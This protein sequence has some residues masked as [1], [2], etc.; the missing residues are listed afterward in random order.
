MWYRLAVVVLPLFTMAALAQVH[1]IP[2]SVTSGDHGIPASVTS[3]GPNGFGTRAAPRSCD[4]C[5]SL[6]S[7][8]Y[9]IFVP[10]PVYQAVFEA[11]FTQVQ[12]AARAN[13]SRRSASARHEEPVAV[14]DDDPERYGDHYLDAREDQRRAGKVAAKPMS[15]PPPEP[16]KPEPPTILVFKDGHRAEVQNYAIVGDAFWELSD[17]LAKKFE[18]RELDLD[19]TVKLNDQRGTPFRLPAAGTR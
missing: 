1:G 13:E 19:A 4:R 14:A 3:L 15:L 7:A 8:P 17:Q 10:Y 6:V 16:P 12:P 5:V 11:R 2:A 18:L 9:P